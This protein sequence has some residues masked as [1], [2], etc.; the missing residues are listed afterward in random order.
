MRKAGLF[1]ALLFILV[2]IA[3]FAHTN[4][5]WAEEGLPLA[6]AR[7][8]LGG[9]VLYKSIWFDKPP[10][11]ALTYLLWAAQAGWDVTLLGCGPPSTLDTWRLGDAEVRLVPIGVSLATPP[12]RWHTT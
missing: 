10:L 8:M 4:I 2:A 1:F 5:L 7:Q 3:R 6:A 9:G 12:G 11:L